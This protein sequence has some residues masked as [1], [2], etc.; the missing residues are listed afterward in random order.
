ME[1]NFAT[2]KT[3]Q[4]ELAEESLLSLAVHRLRWYTPRLVLFDIMLN[5][6][7]QVLK[8][9]AVSLNLT[10]CRP[11]GF[12]S[13]PLLEK[14]SNPHVKPLISK[15]L[16]TSTIIPFPVLLITALLLKY[17]KSLQGIFHGLNLGILRSLDSFALRQEP[18]TSTQTFHYLNSFLS[19]RILQF[20]FSHSH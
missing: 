11:V 7:W 5:S 18:L 8:S 3:V 17:S 4:S 12:R 20:S 9:K 6:D 19:W 2:A 10:C 13:E 15:I 16:Q 1:D 14:S